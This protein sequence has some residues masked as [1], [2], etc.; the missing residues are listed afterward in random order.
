MNFI[1]E[2]IVP[3]QSDTIRRLKS[4]VSG[5]FTGGSVCLKGELLASLSYLANAFE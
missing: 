4:I 2:Y 3:A 1:N 5:M